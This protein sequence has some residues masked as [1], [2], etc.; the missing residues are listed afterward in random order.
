MLTKAYG[1]LC[2]HPQLQLLLVS[3]DYLNTASEGGWYNIMTLLYL[4]VSMIANPLFV[5]R[6]TVNQY[7]K[8]EWGGEKEG[9]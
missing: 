4:N 8:M 7:L 9:Y 3:H 6:V 1:A 2:T 5:A